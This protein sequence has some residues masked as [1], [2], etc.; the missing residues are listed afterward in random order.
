MNIR[1]RSFITAAIGAGLVGSC[2]A[3]PESPPQQSRS[4]LPPALAALAEAAADETGI[5][6]YESTPDDQIARV[7]ETFVNTFPEVNVE[8]VRLVG[9]VD[10]ASRMI[11]EASADAPTADL[12]TATANQVEALAERGL[13]MDDLTTATLGLSDERLLPVPYAGYIASSVHVL[14]Y[15]TDSV[16]QGSAPTTWEGVLDPTWSGRVGTRGPSDM[17][18]ALVDQWGFEK[19]EAYVRDFAMNEPFLYASGFQV[20]NDVA[21]GVIDLALVSNHTAEPLFDVQAPIGRVVLDPAPSLGLFTVI[22]AETESPK[23]AQL[24][25]AWLLTDAGAQAYEEAA[26]RGNPYLDTDTASLTDGVELS[27]LPPTEADLYAS[28]LETFNP[29]LQERGQAGD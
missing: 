1:R 29:I 24:F 13:L 5:V 27:E 3:T 25:L 18:V 9:G 14:I 10:V 16:D 15:N 21:A 17:F 23:T 20:S 8:H 26:R 28:A 11:Q 6:W 4:E 7:L 22:N 19:T 2:S 12:A